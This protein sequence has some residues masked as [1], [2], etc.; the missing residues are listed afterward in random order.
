[1][2]VSATVS[3][4]SSV[5][6]ISG[7]SGSSVVS[8]TVYASVSRSDVVPN[9]CGDYGGTGGCARVVATRASTLGA[10]VVPVPGPVVAQGCPALWSRRRPERRAVGHPKFRGSL[11]PVLPAILLSPFRAPL[12][13]AVLRRIRSSISASLCDIACCS[14]SWGRSVPLHFPVLPYRNRPLQLLLLLFLL[15]FL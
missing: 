15:S 13:P 12:G 9:C 7:V 8:A 3:A 10:P 4:Y 2:P 11:L 14:H 5:S 1:V 6:G